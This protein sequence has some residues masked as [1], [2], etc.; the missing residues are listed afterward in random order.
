M[1]IFGAADGAYHRSSSERKPNQNLVCQDRSLLSRKLFANVS[2]L[3]ANG[4]E[5]ALI[6]RHLA[7]QL[8][9]GK[10]AWSSRSGLFPKVPSAGGNGGSSWSATPVRTPLCQES[11]KA[12]ALSYSWQSRRLD[13]GLGVRAGR[14]RANR[15]E[16]IQEL[17]R[18]WLET[19][20]LEPTPPI[21]SRRHSRS[22]P[23]NASPA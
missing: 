21:H 12:S 5:F 8:A 16:A 3:F 11:R 17:I 1:G 7:R 6:G 14:N 2:S 10:M 13:T 19:L 18:G 22:S 23:E 9:A 15:R 4:S 20:V